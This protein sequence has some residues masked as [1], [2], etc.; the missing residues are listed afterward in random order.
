MLFGVA[1]LPYPDELLGADDV[2]LADVLV[3]PEALLVLL[4]LDPLLLEKDE[5]SV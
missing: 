4:G 1:L 5:L 3:V 2:L